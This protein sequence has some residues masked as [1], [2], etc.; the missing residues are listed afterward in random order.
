[1]RYY[2]IGSRVAVFHCGAQYSASGGTLTF[3]PPTATTMST[4]T[5][6]ARAQT[7]PVNRT[8]FYSYILHVGAISNPDAGAETVT[9]NMKLKGYD[10]VDAVWEDITVTTPTTAANYKQIFLN[11]TG[12]AIG[13]TNE[14]LISAG[15]VDQPYV[16]TA[17]ANISASNGPVQID[18]R[19]MGSLR[20]SEV[21]GPY[22]APYVTVVDNTGDNLLTAYVDLILGGGDT[23]PIM[24]GGSTVTNYY[25]QGQ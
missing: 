8:G 24:E 10:P 15:F 23:M 25:T 13:A 6:T 2:D 16:F 5:A 18:A 22:I 3:Q 19:I 17:D 21:E 12:V 11:K 20:D 14:D 9:L 1:M 7:I 4:T